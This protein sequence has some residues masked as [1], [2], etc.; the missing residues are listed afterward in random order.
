MNHHTSRFC[1]EAQSLQA[2]R[3][4]QRTSG[5]IPISRA[6]LRTLD[7]FEAMRLKRDARQVAH[8]ELGNRTPAF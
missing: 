5:V 1:G 6:E 4:S 2:W 3:P 8:T 7:R